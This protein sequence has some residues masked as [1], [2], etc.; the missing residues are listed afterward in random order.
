MVTNRGMFANC[1]AYSRRN[2]RIA[3]AIEVLRRNFL[4]LLG[5]KIF[6]VFLGDLARAVL[7]D[8][9][10]HDADRRLRHDAQAMGATMSNLAGPSSLTAR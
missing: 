1:A 9:L 6:Q 4:A 3:R 7:V 8:V 2:V 5:I 10:V